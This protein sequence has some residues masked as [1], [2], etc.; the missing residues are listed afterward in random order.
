MAGLTNR[1]KKLMQDEFFRNPAE[2]TNFYLALFTSA[3]A[4]TADTNV[5]SD[6]T[7]I[8]AGNG[9]T[10]GGFVLNRNNTDFDL[11]TEDDTSDLHKIQIKDVAW[12]ASG[13]SIPASGSGARYAALTTD[14][15]TIANRQIIAY[16]DLVADR[17]I[18]NGQS[19]TLQDCEMRLTE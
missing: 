16:F 15:G 3:V 9:Y 4:P 10:T 17:T 8:A 18:S 14:E 1:G 13:G 6:L 2:F 5:F 12:N 11:S 19:L 7:E